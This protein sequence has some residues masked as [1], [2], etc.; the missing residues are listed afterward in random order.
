MKGDKSTHESVK[1]DGPVD[2]HSLRSEILASVLVAIEAPHIGYLISSTT[3]S[4][5]VP[6]ELHSIW[7]STACR[8][9][10]KANRINSCSAFLVSW[11]L[12]YG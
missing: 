12:H 9:S 1:S 4:V 3:N 5:N 7:T 10:I 8:P 2:W 6:W 11:L